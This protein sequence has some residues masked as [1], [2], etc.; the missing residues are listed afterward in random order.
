MHLVQKERVIWECFP[1]W[2]HFS[3]LY[4]FTFLT[5]LRGLLVLRFGLPG[6][7]AWFAGALM[8]LM[9]TALIRHWACYSVTPT[10]ILIKNGFT[11]NEI[12]SMQLDMIKGIDRLQG[13]IAR[14][15]GIGT[16]VI[17]SS[18]Q[19]QELRLRGVKDPDV[20]EAK[21]RALLPAHVSNGRAIGQ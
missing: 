5:G 3:W 16:L 10:R 17:R 21:I 13:P 7:Q 18:Q 19:E 6:W 20:V 1:S 11:H 14:F 4:F 12:A 8:L 15:W 2:G 9:V